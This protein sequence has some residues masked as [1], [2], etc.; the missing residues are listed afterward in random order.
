M[1]AQSR[2]VSNYRRRMKQKGMMR[3]EVQVHQGDA[4][5]IRNSAST[6]SDP[7]KAEETREFLKKHFTDDT[8][9]GLKALL[10][11]APLEGVDLDREPDF[12]R[13]NEL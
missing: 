11:S 2:A 13:N 8:P 4:R 9:T 1:T 6:L 3:V 5:L 10:A 12:G 7:E